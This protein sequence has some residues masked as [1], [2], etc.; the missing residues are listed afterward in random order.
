MRSQA[1]LGA[2]LVALL[3]G[4]S[5]DASTSRSPTPPLLSLTATSAPQNDFQWGPAPPVFPPGAEMAVLQGDPGS[6][7]EFTVRLRFPNGYRIP[8]HTHPTAENVTVLEGTFLAGMGQQ[9]DESALTAY[10]RDGFASIPANHAHF[11][12]ARGN[13]IVQVHA[14]G[15][16]VLTYVNPADDP[17]NR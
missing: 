1:L 13:T 9:F 2:A 12:M 11:A 6:N 7:N 15:P 5:G 14:I 10:Q 17:R 8:A 16:F 4:C 3:A